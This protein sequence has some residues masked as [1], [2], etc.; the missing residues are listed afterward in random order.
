M[1]LSE[2]DIYILNFEFELC[3]TESYN[4]LMKNIDNNDGKS[5]HSVALQ[6]NLISTGLI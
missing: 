3:N 2:K 6:E 1:N 5:T 4:K